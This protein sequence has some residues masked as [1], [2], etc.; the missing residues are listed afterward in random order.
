MA[1]PHGRRRW[2]STRP[3]RTRLPSAVRPGVEA[4]EDRSTPAAVTEFPL[5]T[6]TPAPQGITAGPDGNLWYTDPG[7]NKVG[8]LTPAGAITE[9][10]LPTAASDPRGIAAG[11]DGALWFAEFGTDRIGR[12]DPATGA[13]T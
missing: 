11:P 6:A 7:A 2:Q 9:F 8:R 4:L 12:I 13:I 1:S 3:G 5:A 10:T